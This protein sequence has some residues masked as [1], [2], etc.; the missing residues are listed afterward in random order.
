[1]GKGM[2]EL[3]GDKLSINN[4][5]C[6]LAG[7]LFDDT[8]TKET[9]YA[10]IS[11][12]E[13]IELPDNLGVALMGELGYDYIILMRD[14]RDDPNFF[15]GIYQRNAEGELVTDSSKSSLFIPSSDLSHM[16]TWQLL[17]YGLENSVILF[18]CLPGSMY[19]FHETVP[20]AIAMTNGNKVYFITKN[21][22][23]A[24]NDK[25]TMLF[26]R[27]IS[28]ATVNPTLPAYLRLDFLMQSSK[29][30]FGVVVGRE[31]CILDFEVK[32]LSAGAI[33]TIP[34]RYLKNAI[35][36]NLGITGA[37]FEYTIPMLVAKVWQ[38]PLEVKEFDG[39]L[40]PLAMTQWI[41]AQIVS[42]AKELMQ[43]EDKHQSLAQQEEEIFNFE[44][45]GIFPEYVKKCLEHLTTISGYNVTGLRFETKIDLL[46][47][48]GLYQL[49]GALSK[50]WFNRK[51]NVYM[52]DVAIVY[53][54][55]EYHIAVPA[56]EAKTP[57][58]EGVFYAP[59]PNGE[60]LSFERSHSIP[61][62]PITQWHYMATAVDPE[63]KSQLTEQL[64]EMA[65]L[66]KQIIYYQ[67]SRYH[68]IDNLAINSDDIK[69]FIGISVNVPFISE[70]LSSNNVDFQVFYN[71]LQERCC[72]LS[73][74]DASLNVFGGI[75]KRL[76][77][78]YQQEIRIS[79]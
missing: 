52:Q 36:L 65:V 37:S 14:N 43:I 1:M 2:N 71:E 15:T 17:T 40:S 44:A 50:L 9:I 25:A 19:A 72:P 11:E 10:T 3:T 28:A 74:F 45:T 24:I 13:L 29:G 49:C 59:G 8:I 21:G 12:Q 68:P 76:D 48:E 53:S 26:Y 58:Y 20:L 23:G 35:K 6:T 4:A 63:I 66:I 78:G 38:R 57:I 70:L 39:V 61:L 67:Y 32:K 77:A 22:N 54:H 73:M 60:M 64:S 75:N 55:G 47:K 56:F 79:L 42:C 18:E 33:A 30:H 69:A 31:R 5:L 51:R 7:M 41:D 34:A 46:R 27:N 16:S 62:C